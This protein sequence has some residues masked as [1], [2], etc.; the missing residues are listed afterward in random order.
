[1]F[2]NEYWNLC[3]YIYILADVCIL[4]WAICIFCPL[5]SDADIHLH[6]YKYRKLSNIY[7]FLNIFGN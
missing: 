5:L 3:F 6:P 7:I 1:M 4:S 2:F